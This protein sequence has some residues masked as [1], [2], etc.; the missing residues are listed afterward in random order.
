[1][2]GLLI[3]ILSLIS[4]NFSFAQGDS[5]SEVSRDS[6]IAFAKSHIG[7]PY[8]YGGCSISGFDCSGFVHYVFNHF[9][10]EVSRTSRGFKGKG[11]TVELKNCQKGDIILFTG[12]NSA[13]RQIGHVGLILKNDNGTVDFIHSSSSK[14]H[15]GVTITRY[16]QSGYEKRFMNVI[17]IL[18]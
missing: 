18:E 2:K 6:I 15:Y 1:M 9:N 4:L 3:I 16:N 13:I 11:R 5:N 8:K 14:K 10:I 12:T 17:N 7:T